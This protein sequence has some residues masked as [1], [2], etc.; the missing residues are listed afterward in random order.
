MGHID[1]Y[2]DNDDLA[3][4]LRDCGWACTPPSEKPEEPPVELHTIDEAIALIEEHA[5]LDDTRSPW[6]SLV[7]FFQ[8]YQ[9]AMPPV[10]R[11]TP[12]P[13]M[14]E[15]GVR[16]TVHEVG[17]LHSVMDEEEVDGVLLTGSIEAI[18]AIGGFVGDEVEILTPHT[19]AERES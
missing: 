6:W 17:S 9:P 7:V 18:R 5:T 1:V 15:S 8:G 14:S 3:E 19:E 12:K 10:P 2:V 13:T 16:M 4:H 11:A